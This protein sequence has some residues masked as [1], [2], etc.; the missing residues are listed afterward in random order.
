MYFNPVELLEIASNWG[1][2]GRRIIFHEFRLDHPSKPAQ[3][4]QK[5]RDN[6]IIYYVF[7]LVETSQTAWTNK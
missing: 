6:R 3:T 4:A 1:N 2:K 5:L 7:G